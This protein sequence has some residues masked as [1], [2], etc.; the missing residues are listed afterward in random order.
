MLIG[1]ANLNESQRLATA[2]RPSLE[3]LTPAAAAPIRKP[4]YLTT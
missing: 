3:R 2:L 1:L 4:G